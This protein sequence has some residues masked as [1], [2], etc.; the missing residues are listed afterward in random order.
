MARSTHWRS[1]LPTLAAVLAVNAM[2]SCARADDEIDR[3]PLSCVL[4]P[5]ISMA[6]AADNHT[7]VFHMRGSTV[8]RNDLPVTCPQLQRGETQ[9]TYLYRSQSVKLKRLCDFD[10]FTVTKDKIGSPCR[11]GKFNPITAAEA[12]QILGT[13]TAAASDAAAAKPAPAPASTDKAKGDSGRSK[14]RKDR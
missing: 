3:T 11:L 4:V 13:N 5:V 2:A 1:A 6:Q 8:Y 7:L 14:R 12:D 10:G 9:L